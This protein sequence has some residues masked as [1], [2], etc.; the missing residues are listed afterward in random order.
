MNREVV[1]PNAAN[2]APPQ[3]R[4]P[5]RLFHVEGDDALPNDLRGRTAEWHQAATLGFLGQTPSCSSCPS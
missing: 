2:L 3:K 4:I 1:T 5:R